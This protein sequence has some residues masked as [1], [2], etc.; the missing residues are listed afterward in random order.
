MKIQLRLY[1]FQGW[2]IKSKNES[3]PVQKRGHLHHLSN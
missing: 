1:N 2:G 3:N